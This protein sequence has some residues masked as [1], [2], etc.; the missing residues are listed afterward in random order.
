M[1]RMNLVYMQTIEE[2]LRKQ[3]I[4]LR[5][6]CEE[7]LQTE[8]KIK[9]MAYM[10]KTKRALVKSREA[11]NKDIRI[12]D[13]MAAV[14]REVRLEYCRTEERITDRY[15]LDTVLYPETQFATSKIT[16]MEKYQSLLP[17]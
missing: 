7:T 2:Q 12:L 6:L 10:D 16:G 1:N 17:F 3:I 4:V 11:L 8:E 9:H 13:S 5:L 14:L 15:N